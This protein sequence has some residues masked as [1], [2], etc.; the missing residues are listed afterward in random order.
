MT[1]EQIE[2]ERIKFESWAAH[3]ES[4]A[5]HV[6]RATPS[7]FDKDGT[8]VYIHHSVQLRWEVWIA[9]AQLDKGSEK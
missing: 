2:T 3:V 1:P 4:W 9:R 6:S 8:G 5:A 7:I